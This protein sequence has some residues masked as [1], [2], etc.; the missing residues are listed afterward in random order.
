[1]RFLRGCPDGEEISNAQLLELPCDILAPAALQ[2][3][4]TADNARRIQCKLLAEGANG[5]TTLEADDILSERGVFILPD[6]L[7]NAG[8]VTV[9]YFEWVQDTQNYT[10]T[11]DEINQRLHRIMT[12]AYR[13]TLQRSQRD[14]VDMRT[15]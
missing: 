10:W 9:S 3:Q 1:H 15:A 5:P 11:L 12:E 6:I 14:R 7:A 4:I 13:R 2:N 8:G